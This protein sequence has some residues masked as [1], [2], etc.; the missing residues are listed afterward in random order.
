MLESVFRYRSLRRPVI[1]ISIQCLELEILLIPLRRFVDA[2]RDKPE[3]RCTFS[4]IAPATTKTRLRWMV[5]VKKAYFVIGIDLRQ[6][7]IKQ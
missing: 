2:S 7:I 1:N 5:Y 3:R 6:A 4:L